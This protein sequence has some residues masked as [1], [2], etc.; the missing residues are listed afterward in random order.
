MS[1][2]QILAEVLRFQLEADDIGLIVIDSIPALVTA[3]NLKK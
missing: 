2:E 3:Q 1:G